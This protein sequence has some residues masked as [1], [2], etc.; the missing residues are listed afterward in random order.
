MSQPTSSTAGY[1]PAPAGAGS[2]TL[3]RTVRGTGRG[4]LIVGLTVVAIAVFALLTLV[5]I[6]ASAI[7]W[8]APT[9]LVTAGVIGLVS[10]R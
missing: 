5:G 4:S 10:R 8:F 6:P 1:S 2:K 3:V 9:A 7:A